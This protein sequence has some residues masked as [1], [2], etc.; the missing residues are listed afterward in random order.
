MA[1]S[2]NVPS[3]PHTSYTV[4]LDGVSY[5]FIFR[6]SARAE[7]WYLDIIT[8]DGVVVIRGATLVPNTKLNRRSSKDNPSGI[9]TVVSNVTSKKVPNRFNIGPNKDFELIYIPKNEVV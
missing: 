2:L 1:T 5:Q 3:T 4:S 6:W 8:S 7:V 9:L